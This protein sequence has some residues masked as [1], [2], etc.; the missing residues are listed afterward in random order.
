[1]AK[2]VDLAVLPHQVAE[3]GA[4]AENEMLSARSGRQAGHTAIPADAQHPGEPRARRIGVE[5][6]TSPRVDAVRAD[7]NIAGRFGAIG[8]ASHNAG[9]GDGKRVQSLAVLHQ[10]APVERLI[11]QCLL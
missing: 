9:V 7:E 2:P 3:E 6:L 1:L 4:L 5:Q 11:P 8:E 10:D